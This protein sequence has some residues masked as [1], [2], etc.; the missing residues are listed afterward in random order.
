M[1][2]T[3]SCDAQITAQ[4]HTRFYKFRIVLNIFLVHFETLDQFSPSSF[5]IRGFSHFNQI[6]VSLFDVS[7]TFQ[8]YIWVIYIVW[9]IFAFMLSQIIL[10]NT[11]EM[12]NKLNKIWLK[13]LNPRISKDEGL[14]SKIHWKLRDKNIF[15]PS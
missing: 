2:I 1:I 15:N 6:L 9:H 5:E 8:D 4:T 11:F 14:N 10:W 7:Y 3:F 13:W 12:S